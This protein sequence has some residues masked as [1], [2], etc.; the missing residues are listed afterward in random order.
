MLLI[1]AETAGK[2]A[3][4]HDGRLRD[5]PRV[6]GLTV[7]T[8][9]NTVGTAAFRIY[10]DNPGYTL[11]QGRVTRIEI[12]DLQTGKYRFKG[13]VALPKDSMDTAGKTCKTVTC[14]D[15]LDWLNDTVQ[16][17]RKYTVSSVRST[18]ESFIA[19]HN[20]Q[21][22]PS[23]R[24]YVGQ[25]SVT[26]SNNYE[27]VCSYD[28]TLR[29]IGDKLIDKFGGELRVRDAD[30]KV[31]LDYLERVGSGTDV[32]IDQGVELQSYEVSAD[33]S[34]II[35]R[36]YPL[37][38]RLEDGSYTTIGSVNSGRDYIDDP[39]LIARYG[40]IAGTQ[41]WD[42]VTV[43]ANLLTKGRRWLSDNNKI[44]KQYRIQAID[45]YYIGKAAAPLEAGN[46]YTVRIPVYT[47]DEA[48][49]PIIDHVADEQLR[50]ISMTWSGDTPHKP[51][52]VF[53]DKLETATQL[54]ARAM[55]TQAA[56]VA[57]MP[58]QQSAVLDE[59]I[60]N[61]TALITGVD[62]GHVILYPN[63][64][65]GEP[66][67]IL[68][69]DTADVNTATKCLQF[70]ANGM[71][72]WKKG[73]TNTTPLNGTYDSAWTIDG[74]FVTKYITAQTLTGLKINNGSGTFE[75]DENGNVTAAALTMT[76]GSI[77]LTTNSESY[78][79]IELNCGDWT[80]AL[81]PLQLTLD[82]STIGGHFLLQA[83]AAFWR[84]NSENKV[85][86][87]AN[88]GDIVTYTDGG[89]TVMY[90]STNNRIL[91]MFNSNRERTIYLD[92]EHGD[93]YYSGNLIGN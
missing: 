73:T 54:Q 11:I 63:Q 62:G 78:D 9:V 34:S 29:T 81:S 1:T 71:G 89:K 50:L 44:K 6:S 60:A 41:I 68:I 83:G 59:K 22:D 21:G 82:N 87:E 64:T 49:S 31:Y 36:L 43:P 93:I 2:K 17:Y 77:H 30:G 80:L 19:T 57:E 76:G 66:E 58:Y 33:C 92:G 70:N 25:V 65:T 3:V 38:A 23:E 48:G 32:T 45:P 26:G 55:R 16:P 37:G 75:V 72:F 69:M 28:T 52:L 15:R 8:G 85:F 5:G 46:W 14:K 18:L 88:S 12:R 79:V 35:T 51:T 90:L 27:Y 39:D 86:I 40:I 13:R 67:R 20:A 4:I 91:Q 7:N 74:N 53:G 47:R 61:A 56:A 10:P 24:M 42:D 84:W